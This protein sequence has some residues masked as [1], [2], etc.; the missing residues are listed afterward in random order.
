MLLLDV[1]VYEQ[2]D[3]FVGRQFHGHLI[4]CILKCAMNNVFMSSLLET[5]V[6]ILLRDKWTPGIPEDMATLKASNI[7]V[8]N[9]NEHENWL[10]TYMGTWSWRL[11][12]FDRDVEGPT[13]KTAQGIIW[14]TGRLT[15]CWNC[16]MHS[17]FWLLTVG[18]VKCAI[19]IGKDLWPR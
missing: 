10:A 19:P 5:I 13:A 4:D 17:P 7:S 9:Q 11:H 6:P 18:I 15:N 14:A 16:A 3:V 12:N 1:L 8:E 2:P